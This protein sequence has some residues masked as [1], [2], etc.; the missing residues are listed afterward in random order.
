[1]KKPLPPLGILFSCCLALFFQT[2]HATELD[3]AS[4][5]LGGMTGDDSGSPSGH[6]LGQLVMAEK[7]GTDHPDQVVDFDYSTHSLPFYVTEAD[8]TVIHHQTLSG[9]R[10]A[11]RLRGGLRAN[12][13]RRFGLVSGVV[14]SEPAD[15]AESVRVIENVDHY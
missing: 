8:G 14:P 15:E 1:M 12:E 11:L 2:G 6:A 9:G 13:T 5:L 4:I 3:H 7:L 10:L